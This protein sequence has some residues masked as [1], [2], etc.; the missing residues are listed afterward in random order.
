M[1]VVLH[2]YRSVRG[3]NMFDYTGFCVCP[4]LD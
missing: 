3:V 1:F 2:I 4:Q